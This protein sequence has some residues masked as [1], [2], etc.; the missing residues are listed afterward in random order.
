MQR[1][2]VEWS[3]PGCLSSV[4]P[5]NQSG[6]AVVPAGPTGSRSDDRWGKACEWQESAWRGR[7][8]PLDRITMER[9]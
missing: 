4:M 8:E 9:S 3:L 5:E 7:R 1:I 2:I 6:L